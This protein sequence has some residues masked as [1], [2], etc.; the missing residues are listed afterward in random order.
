[1][2][3]ATQWRW[4]WSPPSLS[5]SSLPWSL[6]PS[7]EFPSSASSATLSKESELEVAATALPHPATELLQPIT[8]PPHRDMAPLPM[9]TDVATSPT[10]SRALQI[11][12]SRLPRFRAPPTTAVLS[13][14]ELKTS[15][16]L[17]TH[18][19]HDCC[20]D[21]TTTTIKLLLVFYSPGQTKVAVIQLW[22][23]TYYKEVLMKTYGTQDWSMAIMWH[24]TGLDESNAWT[25]DNKQRIKL[26]SSTNLMSMIINSFIVSNLKLLLGSNWEQKNWKRRK[27][28]Y[29]CAIIFVGLILP[30]TL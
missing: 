3:T 2:W 14:T 11:Y 23:Q 13:E 16:E 21:A 17:A 22:T 10:T 1:M 12:S 26:V 29:A 8:E 4:T 28:Q 20:P 18:H 30:E 25:N 9:V 15:M 27:C 24:K 19:D 6:F 7:S 5:S